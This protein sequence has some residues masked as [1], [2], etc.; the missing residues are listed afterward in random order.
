MAGAPP[1]HRGWLIVEVPPLLIVP[2]HLLIEVWN[3]L[4]SQRALLVLTTALEDGV[5]LGRNKRAEWS[6][7]INVP[8]SDVL[9]IN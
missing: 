1:A 5:C 9:R 6:L 4:A 3:M 2:L 8:I 7:G